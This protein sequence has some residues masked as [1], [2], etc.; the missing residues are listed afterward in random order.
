MIQ[1]GIE[2]VDQFPGGSGTAL[3]VAFLWRHPER[4]D[5]RSVSFDVEAG[6]PGIAWV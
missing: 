2:V 5:D 6:R 4:D 1:A 3:S